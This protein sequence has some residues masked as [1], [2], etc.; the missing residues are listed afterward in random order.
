M[1]ESAVSFHIP[2]MKQASKQWVKK[3]QPGPRKATVHATRT[4]KMVLV[5]FD[6]KGIIYTN[7]IPKGETLNT[8]HQEGHGKVFESFQGKEADHVVPGLVPALGQR[9]GPYC[10]HSPG[11]HGGEGDQDALPSALFAR[12]RPSGLL[13][14]PKGEVRSGWPL[15]EP[16]ELP[17]ELEG[18][19][20]DHPQ[21]QHYRRLSV[22]D[23]A[24]KKVRPDLR[25]LCQKIA[26]NNDPLN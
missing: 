15:N 21:G 9:P 5:L 12:S 14:L 11:V 23:G 2:E 19:C 7:Y 1:D 16:G 18:G 25:R 26:Q 17:E 22:V 20:P 24:K 3:G 4:K 10:H 8:E 13:P 6:T